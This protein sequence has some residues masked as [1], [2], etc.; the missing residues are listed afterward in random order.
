[1]KGG[2][3]RGFPSC[4]KRGIAIPHIHEA[5]AFSPMAMPLEKTEKNL[6]IQSLQRSA[7]AKAQSFGS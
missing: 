4:H 3:I 1:M 2:P 7:F 6:K 5:M